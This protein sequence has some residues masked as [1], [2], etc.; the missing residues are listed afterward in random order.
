[1]K[2]VIYGLLVLVLMS[3]LIYQDEI[4]NWISPPEKTLPQS[5]V[6]NGETKKDPSKTILD[7]E[8][9]PV[10]M[11]TIKDAKPKNASLLIEERQQV[12]TDKSEQEV[13]LPTI[14]EKNNRKSKLDEKASSQ[15]SPP[16]K[17]TE[18]LT[19]LSD[20]EQALLELNGDYLALQWLGL[21]SLK[22]AEE[23][24]SNHI[25]KV[26]MRIYRRI[27]SNKTLYLIVSDE[28][29]NRALAEFAKNDYIQKGAREKP[30]VKSI[31]AIQKEINEFRTSK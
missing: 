5:E 23:Y 1:M 30:W 21:S 28:F 26:Q 13:V 31:A 14:D 29:S 15:N 3:M 17:L 22:S 20:D 2:S 9:K 6:V 25:G 12:T 24:R 4:N 16:E 27:S 19:L 18:T 8:T 10:Q 7:K 11:N